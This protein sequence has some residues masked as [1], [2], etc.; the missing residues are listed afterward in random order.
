M[1]LHTIFLKFIEIIIKVVIVLLFLVSLLAW[2]A[3]FILLAVHHFEINFLVMSNCLDMGMG[4][5]REY[6]G[7]LWL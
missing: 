6:K 2:V 3:F 7:C 4:W 5:D 1:Y